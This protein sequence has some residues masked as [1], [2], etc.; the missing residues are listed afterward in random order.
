[1][2]YDFKVITIKD[3]FMKINRIVAFM[4][5]LGLLVAPLQAMNQQ[6]EQPSAQ[7]AQGWIDYFSSG[8]SSGYEAAKNAANYLK[9]TATSVVQSGHQTVQDI[10]YQKVGIGI[11]TLLN[12]ASYFEISPATVLLMVKNFVNQPELLNKVGQ[13]VSAVKDSPAAA[14]VA[15]FAGQAAAVHYLGKFDEQNKSD[16]LALQEIKNLITGP[17]YS[18]EV[19]KI[20]AKE[21]STRVAA[22]KGGIANVTLNDFKINLNNDQFLAEV[23]VACLMREPKDSPNQNGIKAIISGFAAQQNQGPEFKR[24]VMAEMQKQKS[25]Q[26]VQ[27]QPLAVV[28]PQQQQPQQ[29]QPLEQQ[30]QQPQQQQQQP[31]SFGSN[32]PFVTSPSG[33]R[34]QYPQATSNFGAAQRPTPPYLTTTLSGELRKVDL[35]SVQMEPNSKKWFGKVVVG[36]RDYWFEWNPS[37]KFWFR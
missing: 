17:K 3:I 4:L 26:Q 15:M 10:G 2:D 5:C 31:I 22:Q 8:L 16:K 6:P 21:V 24:I 12:L 1:L 32:N 9:N 18:D 30:Q 33:Q 29:R 28:P 37:T 20:I 14:K 19:K 25:T 11:M 27:R 13:V 34:L 23:L 35:E 7:E 36:D